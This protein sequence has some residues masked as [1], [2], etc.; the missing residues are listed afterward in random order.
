M[1][2]VNLGWLVNAHQATLSFPLLSRAGKKLMDWDKDGLMKKSKGQWRKEGKQRFII[3]FPSTSK[4]KHF[5]VSRNSVHIV[6]ASEEKHLQ[7]NSSFTSAFITK[8]DIISYGICLWSVWVSWP[9]FPIFFPISSLLAFVEEGCCR[10]SLDA[11][12]VQLSSSQDI[13]VLSLC[14]SCHYEA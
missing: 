2:Q 14:S 9:S 1:W 12:R 3:Y 10:V 6:V 13:S 7:N 4:S 11:L 8:H 5:L